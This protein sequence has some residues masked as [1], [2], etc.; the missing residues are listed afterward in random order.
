MI[1]MKHQARFLYSQIDLSG[2]PSSVKS[3]K[4]G[5]SQTSFFSLK[6]TQ[7]G[8]VLEPAPKVISRPMTGRDESPVTKQERR[9]SSNLKWFTSQITNEL[10]GPKINSSTTTIYA[11]GKLDEKTRQ[12]TQKHETSKMD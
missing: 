2:E 1:P 9:V 3:S 11:L 4:T 5:L 7:N 10:P 8:T 12:E 6:K